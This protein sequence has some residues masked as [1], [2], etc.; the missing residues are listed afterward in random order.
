M[1]GLAFVE[2]QTPRAQLDFLVNREAVA[3]LCSPRIQ[4][5]RRTTVAL[6]RAAIRAGSLREAQEQMALAQKE[7]GL[8]SERKGLMGIQAE[9][10]IAMAELY[11]GRGDLK[12]SA[13]MLD[14]AHNHMIGEDNCV[15]LRNYAAVR[16]ELDLALGHP[17]TAESTLRAAILKE[18]LEARGAGEENIRLRA[19][20]P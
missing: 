12:A 4:Q 10:E 16:G 15:Q 8:A 1:S 11:L 6:I 7:L 20:E 3:S 9:T 2:D 5:S 18:E 17:E 14:A 19:P 13:H